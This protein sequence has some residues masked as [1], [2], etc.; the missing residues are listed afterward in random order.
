[1][2]L[3]LKV[4]RFFGNIKVELGAHQRYNLRFPERLTDFPMFEIISNESIQHLVFTCMMYQL[5]LDHS[6]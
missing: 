6:S 3:Q 5:N 2:L 4:T 1:M